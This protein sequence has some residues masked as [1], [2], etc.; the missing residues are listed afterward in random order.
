MYRTS[1]SRCIVGL[2]SRKLQGTSNLPLPL[3]TFVSTL[4]VPN[5]PEAK[6]LMWGQGRGKR[7]GEPDSML[8]DLHGEESGDR[9][10][11]ER[12]FALQRCRLLGL[13]TQGIWRKLLRKMGYGGPECYTEED[14]RET[15][16]L[17]EPQ[18]SSLRHSNSGHCPEPTANQHRTTQGCWSVTNFHS[19]SN[20]L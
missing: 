8:L 20:W 16:K 19:S 11:D 4:K 18:P 10:Q 15:K 6:M 2:E 17:W 12:M 9:K 13:G 3:L 1:S 14:R 7:W 5:F